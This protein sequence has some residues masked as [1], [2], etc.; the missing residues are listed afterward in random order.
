MDFKNLIFISGKGGTGKTTFSLLLA[1]YLAGL[2]KKTL[3]VELAKRSSSRPMTEMPGHGTYLPESTPFGFDLAL[4]KGR[5]CLVEYISSFLRVESLTQQFF[6]SSIIRSLVDVAPGLN[7][8]AILG[9]LTSHLRSHGPSFQY[10]HIVVDAHSTGSFLSLLKAP[11]LLGASVSRGPLH[12]QCLGIQKVLKNKSQVQYFFLGLFEE[13][14]VDELH[15][16]LEEF[17]DYNSDQLAI[18]LNKHLPIEQVKIPD[19][20]WQNYLKNSLQQQKIQRQRVLKLELSSYALDF[21]LK[22]I[23]QTLNSQPE[24]FLRKL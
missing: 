10:D 13:L 2:G 15:E 12:T 16:T 1:R 3:L 20:A 19:L 17:Q 4:L 6:E 24:E 14:P 5:D 18:V 9:K 23:V 21:M 11:Q 8:L 7:D 22:P